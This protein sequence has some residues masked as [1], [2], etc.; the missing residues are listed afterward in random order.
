MTFQAK[1]RMYLDTEFIDDGKRLYLISIGVCTD[2][3]QPKHEFYAEVHDSEIPWYLA[4]PW[5]LEHVRPLLIGDDCQL[6]KRQLAAQ[7][8]TFVAERAGMGDPLEW[9]THCGS[10]DW[11]VTSQLYGPLVERPRGWPFNTFNIEQYAHHRGVPMKA[12]KAAVP[13]PRENHN[14]LAD[15]RWN[16]AVVHFLDRAVL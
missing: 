15:A 3:D 11:V 8:A 2:V 6:P 14:A 4:S 12:V 7:L 10:Y 9:W 1:C 5:V 13:D 16:R